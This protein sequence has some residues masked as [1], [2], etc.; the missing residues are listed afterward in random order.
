VLRQSF[1]AT[2]QDTLVLELPEPE[3]LLKAGD[4]EI[5]IELTGNNELPAK[6][7]WSYHTLQPPSADNCPVKLSTKLDKDKVNE[8]ETV[9]LTVAV[10]N[11][12][13][14]SQSMT[15]AIIGLPAGLSLPED[16][17]QLQELAKP[18]TPLAGKDFPQPGTIDYFEIRG[19]EL[20][21]YWRGL[22]SKQKV[23]VPLDLIARIPG[24]YSGPASRAYLYYGADAKCW[25]APLK[26]EIAAK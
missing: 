15:V 25:V 12:A 3:K 7:S 19:R 4:N 21:L 23:E 17:K 22:E 1:S 14:S 24:K 18:K 2:A 16:L 8:G 13:E 6:L 26:M 11:S 5:R 20:V 9:R 10:E